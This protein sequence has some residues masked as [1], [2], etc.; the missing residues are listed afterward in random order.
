MPIVAPAKI[1]DEVSR[2]LRRS[3]HVGWSPE[4]KEGG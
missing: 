2:A 4:N 1:P 3:V